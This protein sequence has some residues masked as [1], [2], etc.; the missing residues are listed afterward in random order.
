[1]KGYFQINGKQVELEFSSSAKLVDV[2][3]DNGHTEVKKGCDEGHCGACAIIMDDKLQLS[4]QILAATAV[5]KTIL[6]TKGLGD[7]HNPHPIHEAYVQAGAVQ[8]GFCIP[9][10]I[11][12]TYVLLK[13][14]PDPTDEQIKEGLHGH[15]CRCTGYVKTLD[16][17]KL[18]AKMMREA[19]NE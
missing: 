7:I 16:A 3:R 18:A 5:G 14:Y 19:G 15:L 17:V 10:K 9:G 2:L 12:A 8:C 11:M 1:M 13:K 4:C 6:T